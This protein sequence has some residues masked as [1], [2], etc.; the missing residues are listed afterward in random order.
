MGSEWDRLR[1]VAPTID[2]RLKGYGPN[3]A[4][5]SAHRTLVHGDFKPAN[6]L[7]CRGESKGDS[8]GGDACS[9]AAYDFQYC[10]GGYGVRDVAYLLSC[11]VQVCC[12][13]LNT[14]V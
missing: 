5:S 6:L 3:S 13:T 12:V 11:G 8:S 14:M 7:F 2:C 1:G 10:G 9:C 4:F